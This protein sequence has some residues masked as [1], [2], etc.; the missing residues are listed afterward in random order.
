MLSKAASGLDGSD[1]IGQIQAKYYDGT[2]D[3][4]LT[5]GLGK[6]GLAAAAPAFADPLNPTPAE[7]R[8][9]AIHTNYRAV[10]DITA[11]GGYGTLYGPNVTNRGV[12]TTSEGKI[13]GWE[14]IAFADDGSGRKNVTLMVQVPDT[15]S[16]ARPCIVTATASG[17]RGIYGAIGAS[18]EWGLKE[19]CAV[20]YTDK[21]TGNGVYDLMTNTVG[22]ID[23]TRV[24]AETAGND[25][26]F[27]ADIGP[28]ERAAFN[29]ATPDRVAYKHAHSQ[30]N[31]ESRW[32]QNTLQAIR[33]A[34]FILNETYG[35]TGRDG[36]RRIVLHP[37]NTLVIASGIS[38]GGGG[39]LQAAEQDLGGLIDGVAITEP[40]AQP[41]N[42]RRLKIVQGDVVQPT[43][44]RS[45]LDYFTVANLYQPCAA[46]AIDPVDTAAYDIVNFLFPSVIASGAARCASLAE[47]GLVEGSTTAEQATSALAKLRAYGWLPDSDALQLSHYAFATNAIAVTYSNA[48]GRVS[49]L[50]NLCGF[51][52]ANTDGAGNPIPQIPAPQIGTF[53]TGNGIPPTTGVN[54]VYNPAVNSAPGKVGVR[55]ILAVSPSTGRADLAYEGA[56]CHRSLFEGR[57]IAT[58]APLSSED[59][60]YSVWIQEGIDEVLLSGR[61]RGKPAI[62]VHGRADTL[63]PVNHS[64]RAYYG[65]N[66]IVEGGGHRRLSYVEVTNGQHF[67]AFLGLPGYAERYIPLHV[68][69]IRAL[70]QMYDHLTAGRQLPPS[71]VVRTVPR[72]AGAPSITEANVPDISSNRASGNLIRFK[73]NTL[74]I[75]D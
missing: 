47:N 39:A 46:L 26:L 24:D 33:F 48:F 10:L 19:G 18:G 61:L 13:P 22:L 8:R 49:V 7:L 6:T 43:I 72:G 66:H 57:D 67:D 29:A 27:T 54:L 62:I 68:Y 45:L 73:K 38:N 50:D 36:R 63:V 65:M 71:Q 1:Y 53:S 2:A 20:A 31:P 56:A 55:D 37:R 64:S 75:P 59:Q 15:F 16:V 42:T 21:G 3:D 25:S 41:E 12:A 40:N 70:N 60:L 30:Q 5:A 44:G 74:Y 28:A 58:G 32:G 52:F 9:N 4:L 23:G 69:L 14:Y 17:S 34:F 11:S 35:S 51:S